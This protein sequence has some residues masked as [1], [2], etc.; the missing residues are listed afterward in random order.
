MVVDMKIFFS[1]VLHGKNLETAR[2]IVD[3]LQGFGHEVL[4]KHLVEE[5]ALKKENMLSKFWRYER[6]IKWLKECD[7]VVA[8]VTHPS[9]GVGYEL[10]YA[11]A[12]LD[13]RVYIFYDKKLEGELSVMATGNSSANILKFPYSN[14]EE[15]KQILAENFLAVT[16]MQ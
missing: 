13:K 8:E 14:K 11:L 2:F 3:T 16:K 5:D 1:F 6:N 7:C 15:L 12:R 4:T 9:F 10:G